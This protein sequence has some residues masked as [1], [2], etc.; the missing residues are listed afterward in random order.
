M[1]VISFDSQSYVPAGHENPQNPGVWKKVLFRREDL[2][3]GVVQMVNWARLPI[4]SS[5]SPH[6]HEDMQEVFVIFQGV[7]RLV[8]DGESVTLRR[9]DAVRIE[10]NEV[11][12]MWN[13]GSEDVEYM[14][15]GITTCSGGQTVVVEEGTVGGG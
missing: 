13:V 1:Q 14:A 7:A 2:Q 6:Y 11:H 12:Q 15:M 8:V 10:P 3:V 5:F 9:G 4:G